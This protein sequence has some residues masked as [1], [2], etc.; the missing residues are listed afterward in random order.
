MCGKYSRK[1]DLWEAIKTDL[2]QVM[3][4]TAEKLKNRVRLMK[5]IECLVV[6]INI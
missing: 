5:V 2:R 1:L 4:K 3:V 6:H